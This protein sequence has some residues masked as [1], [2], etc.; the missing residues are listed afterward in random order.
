MK[1]LPPF[2]LYLRGLILG[3]AMLLLASCLRVPKEASVRSS[4]GFRNAEETLDGSSLRVVSWNVHKAMHSELPKD[5]ARKLAA[6]DL[7]LLQEAVTSQPML[8]A[9][10]Q[11]GHAWQMVRAFSVCGL[12]RG[13][14][15]TA[16]AGPVQ[17]RA[18]RAFEPLFPLPKSA[19]VTRYRLRGR[20]DQLAVANVHGINFSLGTGRFRKQ[21]EAVAGELADH[22]GPILVGGDF[23][24]WSRKRHLV[25]LEIMQELGLVAVLPDP[26]GRRLAFG[27]HLDHLFIRGFTVVEASAP[28]VRSSDHSPMLVRLSAP[29]HGL[30][31]G[32][33]RRR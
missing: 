31:K 20:S 30:G 1:L 5:L 15:V 26:D 33:S 4:A 6:Y 23:N 27:H 2:Q 29:R 12:D 8:D 9:L 11:A 17:Q 24:A 13:V 10:D 25:L 3:G 28:E 19:L 22:E 7:L 21:L 18:L 16:R 32:E 14:L